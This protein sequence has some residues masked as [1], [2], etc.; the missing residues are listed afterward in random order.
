MQLLLCKCNVDLL[1]FYMYNDND[2][3]I[4][5]SLNKIKFKLTDIHDSMHKIITFDI[6][7]LNEANQIIRYG[8]SIN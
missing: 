3:Q 1:I 4:I 5:L 2:E 7:P 8:I 6:I